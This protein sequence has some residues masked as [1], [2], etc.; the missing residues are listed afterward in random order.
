MCICNDTS[1]KLWKF[2][3]TFVEKIKTHFMFNLF[4]PENRAVYK[5]ILENTVE[6]ERPKMTV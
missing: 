4:S 2:S 5:I 6:S 1:L 3:D